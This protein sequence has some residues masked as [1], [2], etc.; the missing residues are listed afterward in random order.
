M[1]NGITRQQHVAAAERKNPRRFS[2]SER[3]PTKGNRCPV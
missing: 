2:A 1:T 3:I